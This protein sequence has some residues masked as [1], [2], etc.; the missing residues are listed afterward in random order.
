MDNRKRLEAL[1]NRQIFERIWPLF[2]GDY[3]FEASDI[4][5]SLVF[6]PVLKKDVLCK[7]VKLT[8]LFQTMR[9]NSTMHLFITEY[10]VASLS[11]EGTC[12]P[13]ELHNQV[14][15]N[16]FES[17]PSYENDWEEYHLER[18][19]TILRKELENYVRSVQNI[20]PIDNPAEFVEQHLKSEINE[21]TKGL[22]ATEPASERE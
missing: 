21:I 17:D 22:N 18:A 8:K 1:S 9:S 19:N 2:V 20:K 12:L 10:T 7:T 13:Q 11:T 3:T 16:L 4:E 14:L 6:D 15:S 5:P